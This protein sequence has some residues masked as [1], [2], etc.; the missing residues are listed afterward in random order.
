MEDE[1]I[2]FRLDETVTQVWSRLSLSS[3]EQS[4]RTEELRAILDAAY[5]QFVLAQYAEFDQFKQSLTKAKQTFAKAK[6]A[7]NDNK[8]PTPEVDSLPITDQIQ[9]FEKAT[10]ELN[11]QYEDRT[12]TIHRLHMR[13]R[14][15]F[16]E[17]GYPPS[18]RGEFAVE[19][20]ED[21]THGKLERLK[22]RISAL[23]EEKA[24]QREVFVA[25]KYRF[26]RLLSEMNEEPPESLQA[27]LAKDQVT[28]AATDALEKAVKAL[29]RLKCDREYT[30]NRLKGEIGELYRIL[31]TSSRKRKRFSNE[32]SRETV[33]ALQQELASLEREKEE[34]LP[35]YQQEVERLANDLQIV[36][37]KRPKYRGNDTSGAIAFYK[38]AVQELRGLS[39]E[40]GRILEMARSPDRDDEQMEAAVQ[41]FKAKTGCILPVQTKN[42]ATTTTDVSLSSTLFGSPAQPQA[43]AK[44]RT[45]TPASVKQLF[46]PVVEREASMALSGEVKRKKKTPLQRQDVV[47]RSRDP[48]YH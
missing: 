19:E 38:G 40:R 7:Y 42:Q 23:K 24:H 44:G 8:I 36:E 11:Q 47:L 31:G 9:A 15:L 25:L 45:G 43:A 37:W 35:Q 33:Q 13:V 6:D 2:A 17:L 1:P 30:I 3:E 22:K 16:D 39:D 18:E 41:E 26:G 48:F 4:S 32:P 34:E 20:S 10:Q 5:R 46:G 12:A 14:K 21:L 28:Q 29:Q 27:I